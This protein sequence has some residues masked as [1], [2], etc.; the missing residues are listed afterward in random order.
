MLVD[1]GVSVLVA[2]FSLYLL[3]IYGSMETSS[4]KV[5]EGLDFYEFCS[6]LTFQENQL[7]LVNICS[8][9]ILNEVLFLV[10]A[11]LWKNMKV[12]KGSKANFSF[13]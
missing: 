13:R 1:F 10:N 3:L 11:K 6:W 4:V 9:G 2:A 5:C 12:C 7:V 8:N